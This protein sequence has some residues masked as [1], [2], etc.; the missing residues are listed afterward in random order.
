[1]SRE[2]QSPYQ[3][4]LTGQ[5]LIFV[6]NQGVEPAPVEMNNILALEYTEYRD[7]GNIKRHTYN[8][9]LASQYKYNKVK[10]LDVFGLML[11]VLIGEKATSEGNENLNRLLCYD[12]QTGNVAWIEGDIRSVTPTLNL[13]Q[14]ITPG[15]DQHLKLSPVVGSYLI[16]KRVNIVGQPTNKNIILD[17]SNATSTIS[18]PTGSFEFEDPELLIGSLQIR[19]GYYTNLYSV[20]L[21]GI[22]SSAFEG[23]DVDIA[24][25]A[26]VTVYDEYTK[27]VE[28]NEFV[29]CPEDNTYRGYATGADLRVLVKGKYLK[30]TDAEFEIAIGGSI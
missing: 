13:T 16:T 25:V 26:K 29:F 7:E 14:A 30:I 19:R 10:R 9:S 4:A 24:T 2:E 8:G 27:H 1:V 12:M 18:V 17:F 21:S 28:P 11:F 20:R 22:I 15:R 3:V 23:E 6:T 5:G